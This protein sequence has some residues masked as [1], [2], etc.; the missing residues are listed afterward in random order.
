MKKILV[1][2]DEAIQR[3]VLAQMIR[4]AV[5]SCEVLEANN[6]KTAIE[7]MHSDSIDVVFTDIKMPIMSGFDFIEHLNQSFPGVKVIIL[8][9]YRYFEYAQRAIRLGAFDYLLKPVRAES[10]LEIL[11]KIQETITEQKTRYQEN[12]KEKQQLDIKLS[13]Y[14]EHLLRDWVAQGLTVEKFQEMKEHYSIGQRGTVL[15][16]KIAHEELHFISEESKKRLKNMIIGRM[17]TAIRPAGLPV[18]FFREDTG[19]FITIVTYEGQAPTS[20]ES[21]M[22]LLRLLSRQISD[23]HGISLTIGVGRDCGD[24]CAE[25]GESYKEAVEAA[26]FHYF[27]TNERVICY[28][29]IYQSIRPMPLDLQKVEESLKESIRKMQSETIASMLDQLFHTILDGGFPHPD[30]WTQAF[31]R[32]YFGVAPVIKDF[33]DG[34]EYKTMITEVET[35]LMKCR[36]VIEFKDWFLDSLWQLVYII[37]RSRSNQ[38]N[39][40]IQACIDFIDSHYME[41]ISLETVSDRLFFSPNYISTMFKNHLGTSFSKYLADVRINK[42]LELL[43]N[44]DMKVYEIASKVGFKDDKYFYRVFKTRFGLT[45]DEYRRNSSMRSK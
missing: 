42:A 37:K 38:H 41:D 23:E 31:I 9:G 39:T 17:E 16:S 32:L 11:N 35:R 2:D 13:A 4:E 45:P 36:N 34:D 40:V 14:Y 10:I 33:I 29:D 12:E 5:P 28:S 24:L 7:K 26:S 19:Q 15:V 20:P 27:L 8:S 44:R 25:A 1:V 30:K 22:H 3:R 6:G 18:T 43:K 21:L